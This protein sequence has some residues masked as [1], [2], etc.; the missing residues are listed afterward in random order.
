MLQAAALAPVVSKPVNLRTCGL[1]SDSIAIVQAF[2]ELRRW[3]SG[4][5]A[6]KQCEIWAQFWPINPLRCVRSPAS[7]TRTPFISPPT[8]GTPHHA[9]VLGPAG[10]PSWHAREPSKAV[11][12][13]RTRNEG[14]P[15]YAHA[16]RVRKISAVSRA[17]RLPGLWWGARDALREKS[18]PRF[19]FFAEVSFIRRKL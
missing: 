12:N 8:H 3:R 18:G 9:H 2:A 1:V 10:S 7:T 4:T 14:L 6:R 11:V 17:L 19:F 5:H 13:G 15:F 16:R